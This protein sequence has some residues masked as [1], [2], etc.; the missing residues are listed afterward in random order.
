MSIFPCE[1]IWPVLNPYWSTDN[2][3]FPS[4]SCLTIRFVPTTFPVVNQPINQSSFCH[5]VNLSIRIA[6]LSKSC[7]EDFV[8]VRLEIVHDVICFNR[9]FTFTLHC[10]SLSLSLSLFDAVV[11]VV[12]F[13]LSCWS[14]FDPPSESNVDVFWFGPWLFYY[15]FVYSLIGKKKKPK[16]PARGEAFTVTATILWKSNAF[17]CTTM[18]IDR[19][20]KGQH[21]WHHSQ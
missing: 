18:M 12:R 16:T 19:H 14:L 6:Y 17:D 13:F 9:L 20:N 3:S 1:S 8:R 4:K 21:I 15:H 10:L 5:T 11:V 7:T 2:T